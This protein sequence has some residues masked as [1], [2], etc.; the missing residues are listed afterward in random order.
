MFQLSGFFPVSQDSGPRIID[1][2][3]CVM[4]NPSRLAGSELR[5]MWTNEA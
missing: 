1:L 5:L 3:D 4:V 2:A